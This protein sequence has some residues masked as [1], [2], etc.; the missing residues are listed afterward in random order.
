MASLFSALSASANTLDAF[1]RSLNV[2]QNN[3]S[4]AST[5]G[6]AAQTALLTPLPFDPIAGPAGGVTFWGSQS[7]RD[8]YAESFVQ[9]QSSLLGTANSVVS[10]LTALQPGFDITGQSG[11]S[12]A[13]PAFFSSFSALSQNPNDASAQ[14]QVL[15]A[16]QNVAQ[17]F[18]DTASAVTQASQ[19]ADQQIGSTVTQINNLAGQIAQINQQQ[20]QNP[21]PD[22]NLDATLHND[23]D[24]LSQLTNFTTSYAQDGAVSVLIGGQTPLVLGTQSYEIQSASAPVSPSANEPGGTPDAM[25]TDSEGN[26]ITSQVT[27]GSL[28]GLLQVRDSVIPG[29]IGDTNQPGSLNQL[30]QSFAGRVNG[31][32][33]SGYASSGPPP[34]NGMAMFQSSGG[35]TTAAQTLSVTSITGQ[36]IASIDP[37]TGSANGIAQEIGDLPNS[38][39]ALDQINGLSYTAFYGQIA[40]NF[41]Q[42]LSDATT[43]QQQQTQAVAQAQ[44]LVSQVSG[45]SLD[46]EATQ[47]VEFQNAYQATSKLVTVLDSL[48]QTTINLIS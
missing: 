16:A 31:L 2:I 19:S 35:D 8:E 5:P 48:T 45:V 33:E 43:N 23:L 36:E 30:A 47:L 10:A 22:P 28:G 25:I 14:Q 46:E 38:T 24:A 29:I 7:S 26:D 11:L 18:Q 21:Q 6:Y 17:A 13:L 1:E 39:N 37:A 27:G 15:V 42:T 9:Q 40:A 20:I 4:N 44:S 12:A 41:G 32:L 3:I 34:V